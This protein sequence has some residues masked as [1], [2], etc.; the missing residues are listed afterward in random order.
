MK[1]V[2]TS[3]E[4]ID[5]RDKSVPSIFL[6]GSI[7]SGYAVN[8]QLDF[9]EKTIKEESNFIIFNPRRVEWSMSANLEFQIKWELEALEQADHII[10]YF[11]PDTLSMI[12]LMEFGLYARSGKM[13]VICPNSYSRSTNVRITAKRYNVPLFESLDEYIFE[14]MKKI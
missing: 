7:E 3:P 2:Y 5:E 13:K 11:C 6:A 12:S 9:I 1:R 4:D 10:M 14:F 8:W